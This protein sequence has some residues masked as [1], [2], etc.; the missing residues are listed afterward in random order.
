M[1][2]PLL[3]D[4]VP[5]FVI[6][7]VEN[8]DF[9]LTCGTA[10]KCGWILRGSFTKKSGGLPRNVMWQTQFHKPSRSHQHFLVGGLE[11]VL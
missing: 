5:I 8:D 6:I 11:H 1:E 2:N 7:V 4:D 3:I 10:R 9:P